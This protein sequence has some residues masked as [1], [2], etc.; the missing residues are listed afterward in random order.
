MPLRSLVFTSPPTVL[1][2]HENRLRRVY[3]TGEVFYRPRRC[4]LRQSVESMTSSGMVS[5]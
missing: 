1:R 4:W 3:M 5:R 2:C